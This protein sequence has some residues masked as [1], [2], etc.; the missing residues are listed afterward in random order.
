MTGS[1]LLRRPAASLEEMA[2]SNRDE[3]VDLACSKHAI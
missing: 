2:K 3:A 1:E